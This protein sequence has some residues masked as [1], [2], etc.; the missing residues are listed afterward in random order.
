[1][2][3]TIPCPDN[4]K[5]GHKSHR[6]GSHAYKWCFHK[7]TMSQRRRDG[8]AKRKEEGAP[9]RTQSLS[10]YTKM[11]NG[12]KGRTAYN[13][14]D[15]F[16]SSD[17]VIPEESV[18]DYI[19]NPGEVSDTLRA[20]WKDGIRNDM[21]SR[22]DDILHKLGMDP[23]RFDEDEV[24]TA[25]DAVLEEDRSDI[26]G[27]MAKN[28]E[29]RTF[30]SPISLSRKG[31]ALQEANEQFGFGTDGWYESVADTYWRE[32]TG[33]DGRLDDPG[34]R[35][36]NGYSSVKYKIEEA[37]RGAV[38]KRGGVVE[39]AD[40]LPDFSVVWTST[41]DDIS[42]AI[43]RERSVDVGYP[44]LVATYSDTGAVG[45]PVKLNAGYRIG[46]EETPSFSGDPQISTTPI[47]DER[48]SD[49]AVLN[50]SGKG[51]TADY[52]ASLSTL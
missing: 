11:T 49:N 31:R 41:L 9:P 40:D 5:C 38:E 25:I 47:V 48:T 24:E 43:N 46:Y 27:A 20:E 6:P 17:M 7:A 2:S 42:P 15:D 21:L 22:S 4:G 26:A 23:D 19:N 12:L 18:Q 14:A 50:K 28:M 8:D 37:I 52:T 39:S 29:P 44:Y 32:M 34:R 36:F 51:A 33:K 10:D 13:A 3:N 45:E 1:M 30:S 16:V 35:S